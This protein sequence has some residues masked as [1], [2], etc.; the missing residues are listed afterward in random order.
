LKDDNLGIAGGR[1]IWNDRGFDARAQQMQGHKHSPHITAP[2]PTVP[3]SH[4]AIMDLLSNGLFPQAPTA[5][6]M[7]RGIN[8]RRS[9]SGGITS[10]PPPVPTTSPPLLN[11]GSASTSP[12]LPICRYY[13]QGFCS[14]GERCNFL[15]DE[16]SQQ[17]MAMQ[18][19]AGNDQFPVQKSNK[20]KS[21]PVS[22][23]PPMSMNLP[24]KVP[25]P[26]NA[27]IRL[28]NGHPNGPNSGNGNN[29]TLG[30]IINSLNDLSIGHNDGRRSSVRSLSP[31][32]GLG[33]LMGGSTSP[34]P[35]IP[36]PG[37]STTPNS[38]NGLADVFANGGSTSPNG[39]SD[40]TRQYTS[41][42]QVIGHIYSLCKDQHGCRFLQK[43]LEDRDSMIVEII[44]NEVYDHMTELMIDPFGNYLCQKLLEHCNDD[45][46]L[47]IIEKV[48]PDLVKIS[49]NM[50]GTRAVQKMIEYLTTPEQIAIAKKALSNHV[51][52]L[53]QDLNGNHVIQRC[54]NRLSPQDNQFIYDSVS[55]AGHCVEVATH[56]HGC[57]VLQR[58][59]DHAS[60]SQKIQLINEIIANAL[61][62]VQDPYGNYV[63]QYVLDLPFP[64]L[65]SRLARRFLG[66]IPILSTQKFSSNVVE[67]CLNVTDIQTRAAIIQELVEYDNLL[68]LLQDPYANYVIQTS[69]NVSE[70]VQHARLV[71]A[72]RPHLTS[73]RN[74]PYGK[75]IQNKILKES[76][77]EYYA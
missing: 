34:Q 71:E 57:C 8:R 63:V 27:N 53:I 68:Y 64:G 75:R 31:G 66:H 14:R 10:M 56:R 46:R 24:P 41:I 74:T 70:P 50:H 25:S 54:L 39:K 37:R 16:Q 44:F 40:L 32:I 20:Q 26:V 51:V 22:S 52:T 17:A 58:C 21:K 11:S 7:L 48:A 73:L 5:D 6:S 77:R 61:V 45:Q 13:A 55:Q 36:I 15:H 28:G 2:T 43:K 30:G 38:A 62:L 18:Q 33:D 47:D 1:N 59:I 49:K 60:D 4:T 12:A 35:G 67:K 29:S 76:S 65:A 69:L 72:I 3:S 9:H 42:E 19:N 23:P